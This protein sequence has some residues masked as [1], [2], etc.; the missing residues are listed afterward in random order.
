MG[1]GLDA[2]FE[3]N[4]DNIGSGVAVV[5]MSDIEINKNQPRKSF[6]E[7]ALSELADSIKLHGVIQPVVVRNA[8]EGFYILVAGERRL[9][10]AKI[11]GLTEIPAI[12]MEISPGEAAEVALIENIQRENLNPIEEAAAYKA[13]MDEYELTQEQLA[14]KLGKPRSSVA[15]A[16]RLLDLPPEI[17]AK[18]ADGTVSAGHAKVLMGLND[19]TQLPGALSTIIKLNLNVRATETLV[20]RLNAPEKKE[21]PEDRNEESYRRTLQERM[22]EKLGRKVHI[23]GGKKNTL[24]LS[25]STTD[26]LE[27]LIKSLCGEDIFN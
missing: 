3:S 2:I 5:R 4:S 15:N 17:S 26:D 25:Y 11:A 20:K 14:E 8:G 10:A 21:A 18:V 19:K 7:E 24:E 1:R 12:V 16:L 13:V 27:Q 22:F 23:N 9:R 6:D